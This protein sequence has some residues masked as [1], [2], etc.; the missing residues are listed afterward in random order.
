MPLL[1][2]KSTVVALV[3]AER[4]MVDCTTTLKLINDGSIRS[5]RQAP[6]RPIA[7]LDRRSRLHSL[8]SECRCIIVSDVLLGH[9]KQALIQHLPTELGYQW[10][11]VWMLLI[12]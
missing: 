4:A 3:G 6:L 11:S 2:G 7:L 9:D 10:V 5:T 8:F 12:A 1:I